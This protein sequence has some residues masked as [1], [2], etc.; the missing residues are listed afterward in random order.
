M[1]LA[2]SSVAFSYSPEA[3]NNLNKFW[4]MSRNNEW[5]AVL[6]QLTLLINDKAIPQIDKVHYIWRRAHV[7]TTLHDMNGYSSDMNM[8]YNIIENDPICAKEMQAFYQLMK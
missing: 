4:E 7:Y 6:D 5:K 3:H 2:I 8:L 1:F